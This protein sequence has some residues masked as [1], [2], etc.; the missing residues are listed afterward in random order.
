MF[1]STA[2]SYGMTA[3]MAR[4]TIQADTPRRFIHSGVLATSSTRNQHGQAVGATLEKV[5]VVKGRKK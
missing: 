2:T 4:R 3:N 5:A 1:F